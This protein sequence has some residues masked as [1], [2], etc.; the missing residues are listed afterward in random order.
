MKSNSGKHQQRASDKPFQILKEHQYAYTAVS[1]LLHA[2]DHPDP[3]LVYLYGPSGCGKTALLS[4]LVAEFAELHPAA[5]SKMLTASEFAAKY[6]AASNRS[7]IPQ[8]QQT[9]RELDLLI[10]EDIQSLENRTQTLRELL[11]VLDEILKSEGRVVISST[12]P[13]GELSH[14]PKKLVNRFHGGVCAAINSLKYQS[15]LELLT[16]WADLEQ[17]AIQKKELSL[18]AYKK[19]LSPREL[20]AILMQLQTVSRI[21]QQRIDG[22]FVKQFLDG[23]IETPK[24]SIAKITKAVCREFKTSL[25]EIRS[26]NR[27]QQIALPRQCAM[28]LSRELTD[29]S[30]AK[31]ANYFNRKNHSTVIHACRHIQHDLGKSPALRQQISRIKQQLGVYLL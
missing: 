3:Q 22:S 30:L 21:K 11:S 31:I 10:L 27:S 2:K 17:V 29:E 5:A 28:F 4:T 6:A 26:A 9:F 18:I 13:P 19:E 24:T 14:F 15:R 7:R 23:N 1:E 25:A 8:F 20:Y 12:K 16:F